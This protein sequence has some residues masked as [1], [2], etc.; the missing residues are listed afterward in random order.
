M[1]VYII[2]EA[3]VNH[4][5]NIHTALQMIDA[6][7]ACGC[8]CV[9]FQTFKTEALVTKTA[10]KAAYQVEN[11]RNQDSQ[12]N[13]LKNLELSYDDFA[14]LKE[15]CDKVEIDFMST[16]FD[17]ESV[18]MLERLGVQAYKLSSG[19]I[20]NKPLLEYV[21]D[22]HKPVILSTGMCTMEEVKDAVEWIE[23]KKNHQI[24]LLHCT[25]NYPTPYDEVN[26]KAMLTLK[27]SF[28]YAI[29]YSDH[30]KGIIMPIMSVAMGATVLEKHFTLDKQMDGP[31]H[32]ASLDV[33]ELEDMVAAVRNVEAAKGD[34]IKQPT[35]SEMSTREVA[36]K[37]VVVNKTLKKGIILE[38]E[39]L[40]VKRPGTGVA[41]KYIQEFTGK[42]LLR[43]IEED[44]L[45]NW[46]DVRQVEK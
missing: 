5:G 20:T 24:T 31:D 17:R 36:R 27:D 16:P 37:S 26:M 2:A 33:Q 15:H 32:K 21:A 8:D 29:G 34:G 40:S 6:A 28:P 3:G 45:I 1:S 25:S 38:E 22:K 35:A 19:D 43:D 46:D 14:I 23:A 12:Y 44:T 42:V 39:D 41:P 9:K 13:M 10:K 7:K 30:T 18:D 4:N 11:T